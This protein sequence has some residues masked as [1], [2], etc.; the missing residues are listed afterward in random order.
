MLLLQTVAQN[1]PPLAQSSA[2]DDPIVREW[3]WAMILLLIAEALTPSLL[4]LNHR[5]EIWRRRKKD[6]EY[7]EHL[8]MLSV[9]AGQ[10]AAEKELKDEVD[11]SN[12]TA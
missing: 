11:Q 10:G 5:L 3:V 12:P 1:L 6:R 8:V 9:I 2:Y 7:N 4:H